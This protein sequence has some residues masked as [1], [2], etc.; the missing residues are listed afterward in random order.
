VLV[1]GGYG[2]AQYASASDAP[3]PLAK[4]A[5]TDGGRATVPPAQATAVPTSP[6]ASGPSASVSTPSSQPAEGRAPS[7][8]AT[9][10]ASANA[11]GELDAT[12]VTPAQLPDNTAQKWK[13]LVPPRTQKLDHDFQLNECVTVRGATTWQ[14][15]GFVS[16]HKTPAVQDSL[17]FADEAS[18]R[19]AYRGLVDDMNTCEATSRALQGQYGLPADAHVTRTAATGNGAAWSRAWTGVQGIS[20]AGAQSNH[21]Y[22]VQR[23]SVLTLL[24]FDEWASAAPQSYDTKG[25][26][27]VLARLSH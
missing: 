12:R 20:A 14:Q 11:E 22:A 10:S 13:P 7:A 6:P 5:A 9:P 8:P 1:A 24:H 26:P 15:Q 19:S 17:G 4:T 16:T 23:G 21:V 27:G 2:V 3:T 25:D 18:A